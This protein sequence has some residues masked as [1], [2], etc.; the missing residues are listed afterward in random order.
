MLDNNVGG[1]LILILGEEIDV[2]P[3]FGFGKIRRDRR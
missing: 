2:Q 3:F 1:N